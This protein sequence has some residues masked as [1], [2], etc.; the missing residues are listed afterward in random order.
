MQTQFGDMQ[1]LTI[2]I[3]FG[4]GDSLLEM[5]TEN[6]HRNFIGIEVHKPGIGRLLRA[7]HE[8]QL[9]NLKVYAEDS[10]VVLYQCIPDDCLSG[11]QIFFPDPWPKKRHHKRRLVK[12]EFLDL[13]LARLQKDGLLHI[14][15][16]WM[17]YADEINELLHEHSGFQF[18]DIPQRPRT[19]Y[20]L[21]GVRLGHEVTDIAVRKV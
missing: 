19:K 10:T 17:P 15:T 21:R 8:R 14:A 7:V 5:A 4:M 1:P 11:L 16:D 6:P 2:E 18:T 20:E 13:L 9:S 3:G 12:H